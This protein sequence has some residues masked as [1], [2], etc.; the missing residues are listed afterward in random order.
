MNISRFRSKKFLIPC[1]AVIVVAALAL[2]LVIQIGMR[3]AAPSNAPA[4]G[5]VLSSGSETSL[6]SHSENT[7]AHDSYASSAG[8]V[9]SYPAEFPFTI[10]YSNTVI[11]SSFMIPGPPSSAFPSGSEVSS[12]TETVLLPTDVQ[13][14]FSSSGSATTYSLEMD[15]VHLRQWATGLFGIPK[16]GCVLKTT[17]EILDWLDSMFHQGYGWNRLESFCLYEVGDKHQTEAERTIQEIAHSYQTALEAGKAVLALHVAYPKDGYRSTITSLKVYNGTL[18]ARV[19]SEECHYQSNPYSDWLAFAL[20]DA[21]DVSEV[22][23][24]T[25]EHSMRHI[26]PYT[27]DPLPNDVYPTRRWNSSRLYGLTPTAQLVRSAPQL[28]KWLTSFCKINNLDDPTVYRL[29]GPNNTSNTPKE[30]YQEFSPV[31]EQRKVILALIL[32]HPCPEYTD[33]VS[34]LERSGGK[35]TVHIDQYETS[36]IHADM[37]Q[38]NVLFLTL[39]ANEYAE[40]QNIEFEV[41]KY[42]KLLIDF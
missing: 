41:T 8:A 13:S 2:A 6:S 11:T 14:E 18:T 20:I 5:E 15:S 36:A 23:Q 29:S 17:Q 16:Q 25:V 37:C 19:D 1:A 4:A 42:T 28:E 26:T 24:V 32:P 9:S 12:E 35:L 30:V 21:G 31:L 38:T 39:D 3:K 34:N 10:D 7:V 33:Q 22:K 40:I 27:P